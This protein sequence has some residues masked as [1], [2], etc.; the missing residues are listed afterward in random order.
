MPQ[1]SQP[2]RLSISN[3]TFDDKSLVISFFSTKT[4][5]CWSRKFSA[6]GFRL[7]ELIFTKKEIY[8]H[9]FNRLKKLCKNGNN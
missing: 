8:Q 6:I 7:W 4:N 9:D 1:L 2:N 5:K 3:F